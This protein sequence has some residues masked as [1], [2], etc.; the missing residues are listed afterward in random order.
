MRFEEVTIEWVMVP[1][2][3]EMPQNCGGQHD[4]VGPKGK[5]GSTA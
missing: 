4:T 3:Q 1:M 5:L 2:G